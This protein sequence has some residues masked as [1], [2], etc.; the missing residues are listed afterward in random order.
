MHNG[1]QTADVIIINITVW[2]EFRYICVQDSI[3]VTCPLPGPLGSVSL[4]VKPRAM[5]IS[6]Q[7]SI[8]LSVYGPVVGV[9][10]P[11]YRH[12]SYNHENFF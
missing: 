1:V 4:H 5:N 3:G 9:M 7:A 8:V 6:M 12:E 10:S 11:E 2:F